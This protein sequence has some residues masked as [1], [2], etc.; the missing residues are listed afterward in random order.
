MVQDALLTRALHDPL[1]H[2]QLLRKPDEGSDLE[3]GGFLSSV[4]SRPGGSR[5]IPEVKGSTD[6]SHCIGLML[7]IYSDLLW[8]RG[9]QELTITVW[10]KKASRSEKSPST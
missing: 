6:G 3:K 4:A 8:K 5:P 2:S 1:P 9:L 7:P 10:L